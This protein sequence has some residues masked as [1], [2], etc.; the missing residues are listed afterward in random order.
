MSAPRLTY[1]PSKARIYPANPDIL[2]FDDVNQVLPQGNRIAHQR[3]ITA[4][5]G[6]SFTY[7][8]PKYGNDPGHNDK[9]DHGIRML[10][11]GQ[12][13]SL[14]WRAARQLGLRLVLTDAEKEAKEKKFLDGELKYLKFFI[15]DFIRLSGTDPAKHSAIVREFMLANLSKEL[16]PKSYE[17]KFKEL[18]VKEL[19]KKL[20]TPAGQA[21][22]VTLID[23]GDREYTAEEVQQVVRY[24]VIDEPLL[25]DVIG[26]VSYQDV[27]NGAYSQHYNNFCHKSVLRDASLL[28]DMHLFRE[29]NAQPQTYLASRLIPDSQPFEQLLLKP[30]IENKLE[31]F[32]GD[33]EKWST[34]C[35]ANLEVVL[36][37]KQIVGLIAAILI[38]K[39]M[40]EGQDLCFD[41]MVATDNRNNLYISNVD[42]TGFRFLGGLNDAPGRLG[43][44][45]TFYSNNGDEIIDRLFDNS[46]LSNRF[47]KDCPELNLYFKDDKDA[48]DN[49]HKKVRQAILQKIRSKI[50]PE[51]AVNEVKAVREFLNKQNF[52]SVAVSLRAAMQD[53]YEGLDPILRPDPIYVER[54]VEHDLKFLEEIERALG[55]APIVDPQVSSTPAYAQHEGTFFNNRSSL[56]STV[57]A[58]PTGNNLR[59]G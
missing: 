7:V 4:K 38:R 26:L 50:S 45:T 41:N 53:T 49:L 29:R 40:G 36:H 59:N 57:A 58:A 55:Q 13:I 5:E 11:T 23:K 12:S 33:V 16:T 19:Q 51:A 44:L 52:S 28:D 32:A 9:T 39:Q 6:V 30:F 48:T 31:D 10:K 22:A 35:A 43:W 21:F 46:I 25:Q 3:D 18:L 2:D 20:E 8:G 1:Q 27:V 24:F 37:D 17:D 54:I 15:T 56:P 42:V 34:Q 47:I 14:L